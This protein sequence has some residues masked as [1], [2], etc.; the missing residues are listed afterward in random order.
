[1]QPDFKADHIFQSIAKVKNPWA[2]TSFTPMTSWNDPE[3]SIEI[4]TLKHSHYRPIGAQRV[5]GG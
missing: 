4:K 5:L 1:M 2:S 3:L